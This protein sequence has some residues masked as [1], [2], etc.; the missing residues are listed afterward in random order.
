MA[1]KRDETVYLHRAD[2]GGDFGGNTADGGR[3]AF[4]EPAQAVF[5]LRFGRGGRE[6]V[7]GTKGGDGG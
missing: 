3:D 5:L 2:H 1:G 6:G 4:L 7:V